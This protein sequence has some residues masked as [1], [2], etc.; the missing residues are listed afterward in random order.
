MT[1]NAIHPIQPSF[2]LSS[3]YYYKKIMVDSPYSHFYQFQ[4]NADSDCLS[5]V[6]DATMDVIFECGT[7]CSE[8]K[9]YGLALSNWNV[10]FKKNA[11]YF[12]VRFLPGYV[13]DAWRGA[14]PEL[15][16][17]IM[18]IERLGLDNNKYNRMTDEMD[19]GK[20]IELF[21]DVFSVNKTNY[22]GN[23]LFAQLVRLVFG[24]GGKITV[25]QLEK[26]TGYS[27]RYIHKIF[28]KNIGIAPKPFAMVIKF[29]RAIQALNRGDYISFSDVASEMGYYD[30]SQFI[31]DFKRFTT[32]TP[33]QYTRMI[34]ERNYSRLISEC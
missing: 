3:T 25:D 22:P 19:F 12:G 6:P 18:P 17:G 26:E 10:T 7:R 31:D 5:V 4:C 14:F 27:R 1:N 9:V 21:L 28:M 20:K 32:F 8:A 2:A 33:K 13:P 30:Q 34:R 16:Q 15:V 29:Q 24:S 11:T 23:T